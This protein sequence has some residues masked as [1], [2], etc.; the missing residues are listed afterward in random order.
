MRC[1]RKGLHYSCFFLNPLLLHAPFSK[2]NLNFLWIFSMLSKKILSWYKNSLWSKGL[3]LL[4][5]ILCMF[6]TMICVLSVERACFVLYLGS[7]IC[8]L[9]KAWFVL[10]LGSMIC[11]SYRE[12]DLCYVS[13]AWFVL[14][15]ESMISALSRAWFLLCLK[16]MICAMYREHEFCALSREHDFCFI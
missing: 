1:V 14:C 10:Y 5:S 13:R 8:A 11:A 6:K 16:S 3:R 7:M 15:L 12:H 2:L 9:K 4:S